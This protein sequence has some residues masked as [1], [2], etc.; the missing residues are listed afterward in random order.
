MSRTTILVLAFLLA[1]SLAQTDIF[2]KYY[3][4]ARK[5]AEAM[6]L[7][8]KIGQMVQLDM[9]ALTNEEKETTNP[10]E[11]VTL[12]LGSILISASAAPTESGNLARI[13][14]ETEYDKHMEAYRKGNETNWKKL[15]DRFQSLGITVSTK[16]SGKYKVKFLLGTDAV[17]GDQHTVGTILFPHNIGL[18]CSKN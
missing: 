1:L 5:I 15:T 17:H 2:S 14:I 4:E 13:P 7:D 9:K 3:S 8:Q 12:G 18:S 16:D 11:A 6:S 10:E